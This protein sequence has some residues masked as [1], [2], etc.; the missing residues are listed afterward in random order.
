[1]LCLHTESNESLSFQSKQVKLGEIGQ[2]AVLVITE[3]QHQNHCGEIVLKNVQMT[4]MNSS[5]LL[6]TNR[7][8]GLVIVILFLVLKIFYLFNLFLSRSFHNYFF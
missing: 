4:Q 3:E 1:M 2:A 7:N 6:N 8:Q 5:C